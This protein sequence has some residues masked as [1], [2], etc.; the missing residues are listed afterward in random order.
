MG[1]AGR[2][3][4]HYGEVEDA[5]SGPRKEAVSTNVRVEDGAKFLH[6][7]DDKRDGE[8]RRDVGDMYTCTADT[9]SVEAE[10]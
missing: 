1:E 10:P 8:A 6:V 5:I 4:V 9:A 7:I 2:F 3:I